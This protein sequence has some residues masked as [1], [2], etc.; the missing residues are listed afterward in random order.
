MFKQRKKFE[1]LKERAI[2]S[3]RVCHEFYSCSDHFFWIIPQ[4]FFSLEFNFSRKLFNF[5]IKMCI[6]V[7]KCFF[8]QL[9]AWMWLVHAWDASSRKSAIA[10]GKSIHFFEKI[11][12]LLK[13]N[14]ISIVFALNIL[15]ITLLKIISK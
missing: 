2:C 5:S 4:S 3:M 8:F 10:K 13:L 9:N 12:K 1:R 11:N 14:W 15:N 7:L 6:A